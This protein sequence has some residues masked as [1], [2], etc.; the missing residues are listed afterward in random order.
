MSTA[1]LLSRNDASPKA[2]WPFSG[3][4]SADAVLAPGRRHQ[5]KKVAVFRALNLGDM[6]C[7]V[8]ALRALRQAIPQTHICLVGLPA[9]RPVLERFP[10]CVDEFIEFPGHPAFPER[11]VQYQSLP[12]FYRD[13]RAQRFDLV[14]Q[15]HGS[16]Q[17]SNTIVQAME[18]DVWA[19]FVVHPD[20]AEP[21]RLMPWPDTLPEIHR[22]LA[23][24][25]YVGVDA[26][27]DTMTFPVNDVD[28]DEA[29][30]LIR[31]YGL[32]ADRLVVV[33]P[34]ARLASRRWLPE[35]YRQ[36]V[37]ALLD[38]G[39]QPVITGSDAEAGLGQQLADRCGP[40]CVNLCGKTSLG[41]LAA[42][43]QQARLLICNDTG[44]SHVAAGVRTRSV[45]IACGSDV[46]RWRPLDQGLHTVVHASLECRPCAFDVCP[47]G[48]QCARQITV[49]TILTHVYWQLDKGRAA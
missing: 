8:P 6:L 45:V 18:P 41:S 10:E 34:G 30:A 25:N 24:M 4:P 33:H 29:N 1:S 12:A 32:D 48:H 21:G 3:S 23:L 37:S 9:A 49:D 36:V 14:L 2:P 19:G 35:R 17:A 47:I 27:D 16:G 43:L 26:V 38:K 11:A 7:A 22:Y 5:F 39:W 28:R 40:G 13:M 20:D 31:H 42:L 15:L 46:A 44:V